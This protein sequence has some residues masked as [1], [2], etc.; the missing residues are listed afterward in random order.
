MLENKEIWKD[1]KGYEGLYQVSNLGRV[2]SV[3]KQKVMSLNKKITG[4]LDVTLTAKNGKLKYERVHR[5]VA[6]AFIENPNNYTVVNHLNGDKTDNRVENLEWTTVKG[7]TKHAVDNNLGNYK[8]HLEDMTNK[9][10]QRNAKEYKVYKDGVLIG[11]YK[12]IPAMVDIIGLKES[13]IRYY[14]KQ[15]KPTKQGFSISVKEVV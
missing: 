14:L 1:C 9:A 12:G 13:T 5:L 11:V 10:K 7:N 8:A 2:W 6:L 15:Q 3:R 4:Y